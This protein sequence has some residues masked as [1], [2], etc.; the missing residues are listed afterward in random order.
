MDENKNGK[1]KRIE[2]NFTHKTN[3]Q[4]KRV[5]K[6]IEKKELKRKKIVKTYCHEKLPVIPSLRRSRNERCRLGPEPIC[7]I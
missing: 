7:G 1:S 4:I 3:T 6:E 5:E 2:S